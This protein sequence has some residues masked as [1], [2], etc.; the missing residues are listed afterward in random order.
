MMIRL[1]QEAVDK[2]FDGKDHQGDVGLAL[3]R[4]VFP[5]W[6]TIESITGWPKVG[7]ELSQYIWLKFI[8]FDQKH[9]P[10]VLAGGMWMNSG[11]SSYG[12]D[13]VPIWAVDESNCVVKYI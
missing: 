2:C 9:H 7:S 1:T 8:A 11:F 13:H 6:D 12:A 5:D 10:E 4:L 3:Y